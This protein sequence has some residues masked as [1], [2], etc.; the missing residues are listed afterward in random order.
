VH[1]DLSKDPTQAG[2]RPYM[3]RR[4]HQAGKGRKSASSFMQE[5]GVY[6]KNPCGI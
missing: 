3:V 4:S 6:L 2:R 5:G 1:R